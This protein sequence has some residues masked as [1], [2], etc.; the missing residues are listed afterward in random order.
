MVMSLEARIVK[1]IAADPVYP[2]NKP[3]VVNHSDTG[4][5]DFT[6]GFHDGWQGYKKQIQERLT[7]LKNYSSVI[8]LLQEKQQM[9]NKTL[10]YDVGYTNGWT[11]YQKFLKLTFFG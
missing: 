7:A 1:A 4:P 6:T 8:H 10:C 5:E 11:A 3:L 9:T 2:S